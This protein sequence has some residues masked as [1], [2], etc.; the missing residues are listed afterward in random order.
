MKKLNWPS[1]EVKHDGNLNEAFER[2]TYALFCSR[3]NLKYG[4]AGLKNQIGIE[5][6]PAEVN[7]ELIGFQSKYIE[8]PTKFSAKKKAFIDSLIQ[9]KNKNP[10][11]ST[12]LF[13]V[14]K[15]YSEPTKG[16]EKRPKYI[17]EIEKK[18][19]E[20]GLKVEW[21]FHTQIQK[22]LSNPENLRIAKEFFPE[23]VEKYT[24]EHLE[25]SKEFHLEISRTA[26]IQVEIAK[27]K[28]EF[29][30][31]WSKNIELLDKF[32]AFI[33]FT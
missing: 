19:D 26:L 20:L 24:K 21:Q 3:F 12:I 9:S 31:D 17:E 14:N 13:Y 22:Q 29:S 25:G 10:T 6:E 15:S 8:Q 16:S 2:M 1:F 4:L 18:A 27:L 30:S 33:E 23:F 7:G 28:Q 32:Y 11:L 5:T